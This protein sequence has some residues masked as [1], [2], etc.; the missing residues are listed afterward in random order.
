MGKKAE[1]IDLM[2]DLIRAQLGMVD[3]DIS[4]MEKDKFWFSNNTITEDQYEEFRCYAIE[5]IMSRL[6][7]SEY[8]AE[9]LFYRFYLDYGLKIKE[10]GI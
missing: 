4:E 1:K 10:N 2:D 6:K 3:K 5:T 7:L 9:R 8:R